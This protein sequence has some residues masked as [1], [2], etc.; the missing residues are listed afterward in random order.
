SAASRSARRASSS[1]SP[2]RTAPPRST[3]VERRSRHSRRRSRSGRRSST[4]AARN[5]SGEARERSGPT[6]A[7]RPPPPLT[8]SARR[9][10][11]RDRRVREVLHL[12]RLLRGV[13]VLVRKLEVRAR[14]RAAHPRPRARPCRGGATSGGSRLAAD[15]HP[16]LRRL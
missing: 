11:G 13:L 5:G 16:V 3:L 1:R 9:P 15:V 7:A 14:L 8:R 6:T 10:G 2:R 4:R 12:L